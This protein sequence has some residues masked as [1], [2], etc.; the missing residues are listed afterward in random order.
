MLNTSTQVRSAITNHF[1]QLILMLTQFGH[2]TNT[3]FEIIQSARLGLI[4]PSLLSFHQ[5]L[6]QFKGIQ[7]WLPS[8][9]NL[10]IELDIDDS[11]DLLK[12]SDLII[13]CTKDKIVFKTNIPLVY[14]NVLTL[15]HLLT[16]PI[17]M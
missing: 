12:L 16:E 5:L 8:G 9:T 3:L 7:L 13:Y 17:Y 2:E 1:L 6:K 14:Q 4:H 15:Y 10:P 11:D